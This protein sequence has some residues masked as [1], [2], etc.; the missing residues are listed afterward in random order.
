MRCQII[1]STEK[2]HTNILSLINNSGFQDETAQIRAK[3]ILS[4]LFKEIPPYKWSYITHRVL[5]NITF[6][7]LELE[8][9]FREKIDESD[10]IIN[11]AQKCALIWE[12]LATLGEFTSKEF[13]YINAAINY[14]LAGFQANAMCIA[15]KFDPD[16]FQNK[17]PSLIDIISLFLQRRFIKLLY[18]CNKALKEPDK[19]ITIASPLI[20]EIALGLAAKAFKELLFYFLRGDIISFDNAT[21]LLKNSRDLYNTLGLHNESNLILSILSILQPIK[22]RSIWNLLADLAPKKPLWIRYLKLLARGLGISIFDGRSI[23]ELWKSQIYAIENGL[24][25]LDDNKFVKMPTSAGKTR[26]AELAMVFSLVRYPESKC[27]YIAPYRALVSEIFQKFLDVFYDLG[28]RVSPILGAYESDEFEKILFQETHVIIITPEKLD[29]LFRTYPEFFEKVRLIVFDEVHLFH[30]SSRGIKFELLLTRLKRNL[31]NTRFLTLSAVLSQVVLEDFANWFNSSPEKDLLISNWRPSIQR[32]ARFDWHGDKGMLKYMPEEGLDILEKFLPNIIRQQRYNYINPQTRRRNNPLYPDIR[33]GKAQTAAE[34]AYKFSEIGSV[35]VFCTAPRSVKATAKALLRRIELSRLTGQNIPNYFFGSEDNLSYILSKEWLGEDHYVTKALKNGIAVHHGKLP[36]LVRISIEKDF[37][38]K[39]LHVIIAT[40]TLA[41]G[42]NLPIRTILIHSCR[43]YINN[44]SVRISAMDYWNIAGRAGRAGEETNGL[45]IHIIQ[46]PSDEPDFKYYYKLKQDLGM[47]KSA[48]FEKL[49]DLILSRIQPEELESILDPEIL[50]I[51]AEENPDQITMDFIQDIMNETLVQ[52]Q[53]SRKGIPLLELNNVIFHLAEEI[54]NKITENDLMSLFSTT[55]LSSN[56]CLL[57]HEHIQNNREILKDLLIN[58]E[59][60]HLDKIINLLFPSCL[61]LPEI[62]PKNEFTGDYI[63]LVKSWINGFDIHNILEEFEEYIDTYEELGNFIDDLIKY[64]LPWG[65]SSYIR[66]AIEILEIKPT[67]V[68]LFIKFFPSM[69]KFGVPD[70][71][72]CWAMSLGI[73]SRNLASK[74]ALSFRESHDE[75]IYEKF[76]EWINTISLEDLENVYNLKGALLEDV[77]KIILYSG[78]NPFFKNYKKI[79]DFLPKTIDVRGIQYNNRKFI[80]VQIKLK[81]E[82][83][84]LRDYD[85]IID[86][87]AIGIF[88][89]DQLIGYIPK[90]DAQIIAPEIDS[91]IFLSGK[92]V[93]IDKSKTVPFIKIRISISNN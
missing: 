69:I 60:E 17:K 89:S 64:K 43:R 13:A 90:E 19:E 45:I 80:A 76:L 65:I 46:N 34:L 35:L 68:S 7:T 23:S 67:E 2:I 51:L 44:N 14:E 39:K 93:K 58:A 84:I 66:I 53:A 42:V 50:A 75:I 56:S 74:L 16:V 12:A 82:V 36:E 5:R 4:E 71:I 22:E 1:T 41:Q 10:D 61:T 48:L 18:L 59:R 77:G 54:K 87:N 11:A 31:S 73:P 78:I 88:W 33:K 6:V 27:I 91:G 25:D 3:A 8:N 28:F 52:K 83:K 70:P 49:I 92:V 38:Q 32:F 81:D 9:L 40:N 21:K 29:L 85:N 20:E 57:I 79:D 15:K 30:D 72:A 47:I 24:F 63:K 86:R 55:G 37:R 26:I 62:Q